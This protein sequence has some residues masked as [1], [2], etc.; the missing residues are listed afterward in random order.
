MWWSLSQSRFNFFL[1]KSRTRA[2]GL[3]GGITTKGPTTPLFKMV[4]QLEK[5]VYDMSEASFTPRKEN[6]ID[7]RKQY[8]GK[9]TPIIIDNGK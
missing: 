9:G 5:K 1:R 6:S 2:G 7:Y 3:G 8:A 4:G